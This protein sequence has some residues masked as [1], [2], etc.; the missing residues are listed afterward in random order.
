MDE[1]GGRD[2]FHDGWG[3]RQRLPCEMEHI[4][5]VSLEVVG[6]RKREQRVVRIGASETRAGT[7]ERK[8]KAGE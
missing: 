3:K 6:V 8:R 5:K 7:P 2:Q 4:Q 1:Q